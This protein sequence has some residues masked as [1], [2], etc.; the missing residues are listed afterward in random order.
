MKLTMTEVV[1]RV[2]TIEVDNVLNTDP[3]YEPEEDSILRDRFWNEID[4]DGW[5]V[6]YT[7]TCSIEVGEHEAQLYRKCP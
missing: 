4:R 5:D 6:E 1:T 3:D 7:H 2:K